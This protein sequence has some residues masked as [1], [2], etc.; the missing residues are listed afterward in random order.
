MMS[1]PDNYEYKIQKN[2]L[3]HI[4]ELLQKENNHESTIE[5]RF[6][7]YVF[8]MGEGKMKVSLEEVMGS[9]FSPEKLD[10]LDKNV[11]YFENLLSYE[12]L[13]GFL[14]VA[15]DADICE[16]FSME[17]EYVIYKLSKIWKKLYYQKRNKEYQMHLPRGGVLP[18]SDFF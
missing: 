11:C 2:Y 13:S 15:K 6:E 12:Q 18:R 7:L 3:N 4:L 14:K 5:E 1:R 16:E 17:D 8:L 10:E 9:K